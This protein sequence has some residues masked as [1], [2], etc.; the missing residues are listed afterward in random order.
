MKSIEILQ[1]LIKETNWKTCKELIELM[2]NIET[3]V[4]SSD[5][6]ETVVGNM[7]LRVLKII[8]DEHTLSIGGNIEAEETIHRIIVPEDQRD[9]HIHVPE[10]KES[11]L[12]GLNELISELDTSASNIASQ[13]LEHIYS[14]YSMNVLR[15]L[16]LFLS[17]MNSL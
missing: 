11:I 1:T 5:L 10:L 13:S 2:K 14:V 12:D 7:V 6:T 9:Y 17:R 16:T 3:K 8:R 15:I 4:R